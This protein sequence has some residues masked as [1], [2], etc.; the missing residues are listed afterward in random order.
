MMGSHVF[1]PDPLFRNFAPDGHAGDSQLVASS[2]VA[3]HQHADSVP[4]VFGIEHS[5]CRANATLEFVADH[6]GTA[7]YISFFNR[8]GMCGIE[9]MKDVLGLHV[10]TVHIVQ[11]A[12]PVS[13]T[14]G[15]DHQ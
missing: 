10:K 1:F 14:T 3:L 15:N 7:A 4:T 8:A 5:G 9:R 12:V 6:P 13:A 2:V 11:I